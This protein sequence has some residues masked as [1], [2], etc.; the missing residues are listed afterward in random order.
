MNKELTIIF[1]G[2][3]SEKKIIKYLKQ[4]KKYFKVIIIE[5]SKD[6]S[7]VKK[8]KKFSNAKVIVNNKNTG[9]G[10]GINLALK[11]VKTKYAL[12]IDLDTIFSNKSINDLVEQANKLKDF[13]IIGP[14]VKNFKYQ[15]DQFIKRKISKNT[16]Q[17]NFIDG[18]CLLFN[19]KQMRK[20][21]FF[22][23][24]IFLY[25]EETDLIKRCVDKSKK[26]LMIDNIKIYHEG[27]SSSSDELIP[28]I[29]E[30]RNW[31]YMWSKFYYFRK[32]Y[33]YLYAFFKISRHFIS[34]ILKILI[35]HITGNEKKKLIYLARFS[36]CINAM[37]LKKSW[38]R[39]KI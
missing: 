6:Y 8:I 19:M 18:C 16:N 4:F 39:P 12:Q 38:F 35:N 21:G 31:H 11:K 2:F 28:I 7:L 9:F 14:F 24:N 23:T 3:Y 15:E 20:I 32:H 25:F 34:A 27:R 10:A 13:A 17:M 5:N 33:N 36:G 29:E 26:V 30:N 1:V 37:M 22:D